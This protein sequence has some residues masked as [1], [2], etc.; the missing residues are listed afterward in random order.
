MNQ[1][2]WIQIREVEMIE[3]MRCDSIVSA[4]APAPPAGRRGVERNTTSI[5]I[6]FLPIHMLV[7]ISNARILIRYI[8][9]NSSLKIFFFIRGVGSHV[10]F[11]FSLTTPACAV[12]DRFHKIILRVSNKRKIRK[13]YVYT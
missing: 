9:K 10:S 4:E 2:Q 13:T 11:F 6:R 1:V 7:C 5:K 8:S 12:M 3:L